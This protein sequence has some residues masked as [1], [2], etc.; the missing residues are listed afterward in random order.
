M[1][2]IRAAK[3]IGSGGAMRAG[4]GE[5]AV[6][7][8]RTW[9]EWNDD[10]DLGDF[11]FLLTKMDEAEEGFGDM[12]LQPGDREEMGDVEALTAA[13][14]DAGAVMRL[15]CRECCICDRGD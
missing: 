3:E 10:K 2:V 11:K 12:V 14:E 1:P 5:L 9:L 7:K 4:T 13:A 8:A 6:M 15:F